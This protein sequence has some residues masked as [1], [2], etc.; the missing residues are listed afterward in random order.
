[1]MLLLAISTT[2]KV[3]KQENQRS[4]KGEIVSKRE[5]DTGVMRAQQSVQNI[6]PKVHFLG[7]AIG[8]DKVGDSERISNKELGNL[9][10]S[11]GLFPA[12]LVAQAGQSVVN[13]HDGVNERVQEGEDPHSGNTSNSHGPQADD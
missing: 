1:M 12:R 10:G 4:N 2:S 13:V 8:D 5:H 6:L 11:E 7:E 3:V 9:H